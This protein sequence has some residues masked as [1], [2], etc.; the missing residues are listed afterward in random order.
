MSSAALHPV[1]RRFIAEAGAASHSL[2]F[3]RVVGQIY[4]FLYFAEGPRSLNDLQEAL[5]I[6]KGS[7]SMGVRQLEHWAAVTKVPI[8]GDRKDYYE[9]SD[10]FAPIIR[11]AIA[12]TVSTKMHAAAEVI[13]ESLEQVDAVD[14]DVYLRGRLEHLDAFR[15]R[16]SQLWANPFLQHFLK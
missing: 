16:I 3:G 4:A 13:G 10:S 7:A 8:E 6:S 12:D 1:V 2:G 11:N 9:A 15:G 14:D 5:G